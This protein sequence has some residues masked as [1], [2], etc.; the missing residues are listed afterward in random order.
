MSSGRVDLK[1]YIIPITFDIMFSYVIV[2]VMQIMS[3]TNIPR[4]NFCARILLDQIDI[5]G[6][7]FGSTF[8]VHHPPC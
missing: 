7:H 2:L 8:W 5:L 6:P 4:Y 1:R 3:I